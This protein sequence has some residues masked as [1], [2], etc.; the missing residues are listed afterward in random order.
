[1]HLMKGSLEGRKASAKP[2]GSKVNI[3]SH[4]SSGVLLGQ[5]ST[6]ALRLDYYNYCCVN[7]TKGLN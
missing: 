3:K 6:E 2:C 4:K 1:M 7:D 5:Y